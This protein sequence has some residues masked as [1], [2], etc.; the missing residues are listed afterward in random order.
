MRTMMML[1]LFLYTCIDDYEK[2]MNLQLTNYS[3]CSDDCGKEMFF[4]QIVVNAP[5]V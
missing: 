2:L 5:Y 3:E 1:V 4:I